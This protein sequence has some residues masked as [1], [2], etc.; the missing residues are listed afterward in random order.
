MADR[1]GVL[2][3]DK[4]GGATSHDVIDRVRRAL[5]MKHI[6]HTGT[7]DPFATGVLVLCLG[8]ATRLQRF[9]AQC[10]KEYVARIRLGFATDTYDRTGTPLSAIV[11]SNGV[12]PEQIE[13]L[14]NGWRG[15]Q[16][17]LPPM[18]SAKKQ[19]GVRLYKLARRGQQVPRK[20]VRVTFYDLE[21]L[22]EGKETIQRNPDGTSD[23]SIRVRC[24]AGTYI[25]TLA[26][27]LG[28]QF[29]C[30]GHLIELRRTAVG[31]FRLQDAVPLGEFED[32]ALQG[33][34]QTRII[35][36]VQAPL[37]MPALT[38][39]AGEVEM[40]RHGQAMTCDRTLDGTYCKLLDA[41]GGLVAVGE[42]LPGGR[43][44]QPRVVLI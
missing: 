39:S 3:I 18:F 10:D 24:S 44:I 20:P 26:H 15:P 25:R 8:K 23:F 16:E 40:V 6:G 42:V 17:Q 2:I 11:A 43:V 1:D 37:A 21:L 36:L 41:Q 32:L 35:P 31:E 13:L 12:M 33:Q 4:P 14:I 5:G 19:E 38:L 22:Q 9:F 28:Q 30:G 34:A 7:L 29:G 27:D